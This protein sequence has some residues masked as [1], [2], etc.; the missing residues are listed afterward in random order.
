MAMLSFSNVFFLPNKF[1]EN[2]QNTM[3]DDSLLYNDTAVLAKLVSPS[4]RRMPRFFLHIGP[5][6]TA[7]TSIQCALYKYQEELKRKDSILFLGKV[8]ERFCP[9]RVNSRAQD[10]RIRNIHLCTGDP[11]C[12]EKLTSE[13][14]VNRKKGYDMVLSKEGISDLGSLNH[15]DATERERFWSAMDLAL[16]GWNVTVILTYRRFFEWLPSSFNQHAFQM[17]LQ[18]RKEPWPLVPEKPIT[19]EDVLAGVLQGTMIPPYPFVDTIRQTQLP[20]NWDWYV[21]NMH[22]TPD[23]VQ[24]F[25]CKVLD[26]RNTCSSYQPIPQSRQSPGDDLVYDYLNVQALQWGWMRQAPRGQ[27][28]RSTRNFVQNV[29]KVSPLDFPQ[30]CP[31]RSLLESL[32]AYSMA[33]E[34]NIIGSVDAK[35]HTEPF[36]RFSKSLCTVNATAVLLA[37]ATTWKTFY[38]SV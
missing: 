12:W 30:D 24:A 8:D 35:D 19:L 21:M 28:A 34:E 4:K 5:H 17:R 29:L 16:V 38:A 20:A 14:E 22:Q 11:Q 18:S 15:S 25:V 27:R 36:W 37:N 6:K 13:W 26:A 23:V 33:L 7:T 3:R 31:S 32:L 9:F 10:Q 1:L 2:K